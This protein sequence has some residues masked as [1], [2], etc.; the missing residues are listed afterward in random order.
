M[1]VLLVR[2]GRSLYSW[3]RYTGTQIC[4]DPVRRLSAIL[5]TN[6]VYPD[7]VGQAAQI[8]IVRQQFSNAIVQIMDRMDNR[9]VELIDGVEH[10][11][12]YPGPNSRQYVM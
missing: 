10:F 12:T 1:L 3:G 4:N 5:L 9:Q 7:A 11:T 6:R 8:R 2:G